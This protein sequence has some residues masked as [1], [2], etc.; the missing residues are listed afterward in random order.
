MVQGLK[1]RAEQ[2]SLSW[3]GAVKKALGA[4]GCES[5]RVIGTGKGSH[6]APGGLVFYWRLPDGHPKIT[7]PA[8]YGK[9][10]K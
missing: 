6:K 3:G 4:L 7:N 5:D 1:E 10:L 9:V 2:D 8:T